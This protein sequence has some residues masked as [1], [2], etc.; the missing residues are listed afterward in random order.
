MSPKAKTSKTG[1]RE[2]V[3][4][5]TIDAPPA[6][7]FRAWSD[8]ELLAQWFA[9]KPLTTEV[10]AY[11]LRPG[12]SFNVVMR[13]AD[14]AAYPAAGVFLD[15][16]KNRRIVWT[17]AFTE[18]WV[19]SE[20]AFMLAEITLEEQGGG[21]AYRARIRHWTAADREAHEKMGFHEGWAL[22]AEQLAALV[23]KL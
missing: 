18:T 4:T 9:P 17:D 11:D 15:V 12:G 1:D 13:G 5:R 23:A 7:V 20:K 22:C 2:L 8:P 6:S 16:V 19:P 3:L 10:V 14:G 21:T